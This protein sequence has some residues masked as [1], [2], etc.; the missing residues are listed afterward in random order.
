MAASRDES[1]NPPA[2]AETD[3]KSLSESKDEKDVGLEP[4]MTTS[5]GQSS[6]LLLV[7]F[8][9]ALQSC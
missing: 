2:H 7:G 5:A 3:Q 8:Y 9:H 6:G 4:V 1:N